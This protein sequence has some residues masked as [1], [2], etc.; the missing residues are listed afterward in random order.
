MKC[1]LP[2]S[3]DYSGRFGV[4]RITNEHGHLS[5]SLTEADSYEHAFRI[6]SARMD[7]GDNTD[8]VSN[9]LVKLED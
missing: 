3:C 6:Y 9:V 4:V 2:V 1:T 5:Y 7:L 8:C